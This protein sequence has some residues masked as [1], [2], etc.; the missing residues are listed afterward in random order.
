VVST[1]SLHPHGTGRSRLATNEGSWLLFNSWEFVVFFVLVFALYRVLPARGQN[2]LL[3]VASYFFYG[4]W[5]WRFLG[6]LFISTAIDYFVGKA[7]PSVNPHRRRILLISSVAAQLAMLGFFKYFNFFIDSAGSLLVSLGFNPNVPSLSVILPVG[8]SFYTFQT[9]AYTIDVYRQRIGPTTD[10]LLFALY[11]SYFPQL[12]AGPIE[13]PD[14]LIPQFTQRRRATSEQVA[15][16]ALLILIGL[17]RKVVIADVA[18]S[19]VDDVFSNPSGSTGIGLLVGALVF[20]LQ[21]YGD[22]AGYTDMAR[23]TSR[24]LGIEL[25]ENFSHPYFATSIASFWRRWHISLSTW[26]RDYLYIPLGGNR[27]GRARTYRNLVLTMVLGG[28]WHGAAWTFVIWGAI[29][30]VALA[31]ERWWHEIRPRRQAPAS[32]A[33]RMGGWALTMAVVTFAWVFFRSSS[34][35]TAMNIVR[36]I[37][38]FEGGIDRPT[39]V[40]VGWFL[41]LS[42]FT[43]FIDLPQVLQR[44]H[45]A[46]LD[47][48]YLV[49]G[50]TYAG[51]VMAILLAPTQANVPFIYFQF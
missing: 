36:R 17:T 51:L 30:G 18:A 19:L 25:M 41:V 14:H 26:L 23:G 37:A 16:G 33:G 43:L 2:A 21:I 13:R 40:L 42:V 28:L 15:S 48:P 50:V 29:H 12:V 9:M 27:Q 1:S 45:T 11:V 38:T 32:L 5:D 34:L 8:I 7:M 49:R 44:S 22:F 46:V 35:T 6:L 20:A 47:W 10:P 39:L 3:L 31:I 4:W 24:M